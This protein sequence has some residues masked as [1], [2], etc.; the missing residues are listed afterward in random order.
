MQFFEE[1]QSAGLP[2]NAAVFNGLIMGYGKSN[3]ADKAKALLQRMN[4]AGIMPTIVTYNAVLDAF[5][6]EKRVRVQQG[7]RA[8]SSTSINLVL[9]KFFSDWS[10]WWGATIIATNAVL[11]AF[12]NGRRMR[13]L[14]V[15][16]QSF[17]VSGCDWARTAFLL[18]R[19]ALWS[20]H[21]LQH[22][23]GQREDRE[24]F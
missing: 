2:G 10:L 3:Q 5:A 16:L 15:W 13:G 6:N 19:S 14:R 9:Q 20:Q 4:R 23:V 18:K 11:D 22:C 8:E 7:F 24:N 17:K 12:A 1:M 21:L